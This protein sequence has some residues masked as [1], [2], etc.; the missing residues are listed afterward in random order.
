MSDRFFRWT[1]GILLGMLLLS[2]IVPCFAAR[3]VGGA[4]VYTLP[5]G[6]TY[7]RVPVV[8]LDGHVTWIDFA[9][10]ENTRGLICYRKPYVMLCEVDR[11]GHLDVMPF[12][13]EMGK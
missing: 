1:L 4:P 10:T 7:T 2:Y 11:L 13:R 9:Y 6:G 8:E 12:P 5:D 3:Y